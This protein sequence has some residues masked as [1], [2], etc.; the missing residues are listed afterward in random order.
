MKRAVKWSIWMFALC[1]IVCLL[2]TSVYAADID[3]DS[4]LKVPAK[5]AKQEANPE[6]RMAH[7]IYADPDL[8]ATTG[9]FDG[10]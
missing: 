8:S 5:K 4:L 6:N 10:L 7:N 2:Q 3:W 9:K 1:M